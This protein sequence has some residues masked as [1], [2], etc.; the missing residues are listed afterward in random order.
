LSS[1]NSN[2]GFDHLPKA[3]KSPSKNKPQDKNEKDVRPRKSS[4]DSDSSFNSSEPEPSEGLSE[5]DSEYDSE[6]ASDSSFYELCRERKPFAQLAVMIQMEYA[7]GMTLKEYMLDHGRSDEEGMKRTEIFRLFM[8]LMHALKHIHVNGLV[9]RDIKPD[10]IFV[11]R[12]TNK[13]LIGDFGLAK[14]LNKKGSQILRT[15]FVPGLSKNMSLCNLNH[16]LKQ[17]S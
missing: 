9:H 16:G 5:Y 8:Q 3:N 17:P 10:N 15:T 14:N 12:H 6:C 4:F 13:L 7:D 1:T 2:S 11:N